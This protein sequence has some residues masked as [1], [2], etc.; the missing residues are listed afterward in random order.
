[1]QDTID[2]VAALGFIKRQ[3]DEPWISCTTT[4]ATHLTWYRNNVLHLFA[5]PALVALLINRAKD[6]IERQQMWSDARHLP[7]CRARTLY[8][9][10]ATP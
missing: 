2:Q 5:A 8:G 10:R 9:R 7:I 1:M 3:S 4:A 6:G